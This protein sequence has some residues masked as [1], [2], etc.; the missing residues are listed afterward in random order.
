MVSRMS[1]VSRKNETVKNFA[2]SQVLISFRS[3]THPAI[4]DSLP[5][6]TQKFKYLQAVDDVDKYR[7]KGLCT[8]HLS[9]QIHQIA[10]LNIILASCVR[11]PFLEKPCISLSSS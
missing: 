9:F 5:Q 3:S 2:Q 7:N 4:Q 6:C 8:P 10:H 1:M 11:G